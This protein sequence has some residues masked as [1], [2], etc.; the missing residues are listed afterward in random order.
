LLS[1]LFFDLGL[2]LSESSELL[3]DYLHVEVVRG[4][5]DG[6]EVDLLDIHGCVY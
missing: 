3:L 4:G 5:A 2:P 1:E 6:P